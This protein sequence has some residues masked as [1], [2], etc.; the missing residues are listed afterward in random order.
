[1]KFAGV[2]MVRLVA[3]DVPF[4]LVEREVQFRHQGFGPVWLVRMALR[5]KPPIGLKSHFEFHLF[6]QPIAQHFVPSAP[7]GASRR[8]GRLSSGKLPG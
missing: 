3:F 7:S 1:M 8:A 5:G 4:D 2:R 6:V